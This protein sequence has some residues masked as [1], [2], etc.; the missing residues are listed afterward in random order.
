MMRGKLQVTAAPGGPGMR[1]LSL[2]LAALS[3]GTIPLSCT[4]RLSPGG[5]AWQRRGEAGRPNTSGLTRQALPHPP[6]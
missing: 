3:L 6:L 1:L 4:V 5:W 2:S